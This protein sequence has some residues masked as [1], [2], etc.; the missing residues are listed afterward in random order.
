MA[1][2]LDGVVLLCRYF[3]HF[4]PYFPVVRSRDP[5]SCYKTGP[6]LFWA[7][8]AT[9]CRRYAKKEGIFQFLVDMLPSEIW[10]AAAQPPLRQPTI[11]AILLLVAWPQPSIRFMSD[12]SYIFLGIALNSCLSLGLHTGKGCHPEFTAQAYQ[13]NTTDEEA[14]YTWAACNL[15]SQRLV[16]CPYS[17]WPQITLGGIGRHR[18]MLTVVKQR[19]HIYGLSLDGTIVWKDN[20]YDSRRDELLCDAPQLC[21]AAGNGAVRK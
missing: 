3:E 13:L 14:T 8:I 11:N 16:E 2:I 19:L 5:D 20:R 15:L 21:L 18:H 4:H 12:P 10:A 17:L 9:A 6:I 1:L 7:I